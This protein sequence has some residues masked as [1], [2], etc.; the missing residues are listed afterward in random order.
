MSRLTHEHSSQSSQGS[1]DK[2]FGD[3]VSRTMLALASLVYHT[4]CVSDTPAE[5]AIQSIDMTN[6][7]QHFGLKT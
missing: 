4:R 7:V 2:G 3:Q 5:Y 6:N 1:D